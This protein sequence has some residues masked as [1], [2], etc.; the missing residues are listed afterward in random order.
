MNQ[1]RGPFRAFQPAG[2]ARSY[3]AEGSELKAVN[4]VNCRLPRSHAPTLS[5]SQGDPPRWPSARTVT[6][7]ALVCQMLGACESSIYDQ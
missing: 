4:Q 7:L 1:Y 5:C 6:F 3:S 2:T